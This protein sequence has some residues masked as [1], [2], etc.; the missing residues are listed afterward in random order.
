MTTPGRPTSFR[1]E[2][3]R[4]ARNFCL[5]GATNAQLAKFLGVA[6]RTID[7]W[8]AD[9]PEFA[10]AVH[11]GRIAADSE[12]WGALF[13]RACGATTTT[14]TV[15]R[16]RGEEK[17]VTKTVQHLPDTRAIDFWLHNPEDRRKWIGDF[18]RDDAQPSDD[19]A[20]SDDDAGRAPPRRSKLH[21]EWRDHAFPVET[22][23]DAPL[24][25]RAPSAE[26]SGRPP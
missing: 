4:M 14:T 2:F 11:E 15:T 10:A 13:E 5:I 3:C 6:P 1:P 7:N 21:H 16:Q 22:S 24:E 26:I 17:T 23:D 20:E 19:P 8:I 12:V 9:M 18:M 25:W